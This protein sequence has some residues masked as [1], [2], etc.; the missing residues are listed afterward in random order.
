MSRTLSTKKAVIAAHTEYKT[1]INAVVKGLHDNID[2]MS[3]ILSHGID[4]GYGQ[5]IYCSDT[6]A[7][8]MKHR[9]H[10]ITLLEERA[11]GFDMEVVEMVANFGYF[12]TNKMDNEDR[13]QLYRYLGGGKPEQCTITN[14]MCW[15]AVE[16]VCRWFDE[17]N[18]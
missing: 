12:R 17:D 7:F 5:F 2:C 18:Y 1:L 16:E 10:I 6:H 11:E 15:Y 14:L 3:D 13:K 4:G 9:K 8:A